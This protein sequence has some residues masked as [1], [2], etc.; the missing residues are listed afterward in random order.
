MYTID[1][2]G[3]AGWGDVPVGEGPGGTCTNATNEPGTSDQDALHHVT[4]PGYYGGHPNPTRGNDGNTFNTSIPQSPVSTDNPVECDYRKSGGTESTAL[5]VFASSTN[6]I[7]EYT[8][9]NFGGSLKGELIAAG[10]VKDEIYRIELNQAG[11]AVTA[12]QVL[13]SSVVSGPLDLVTKGDSGPGRPARSGSRPRRAARSSSSSR[14]TSA[15]AVPRAADPTIRRSTR[16]TTGTR[17]PTRSTTAR[18]PVRPATCRR[19]GT[20]TTYR[21]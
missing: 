13:F 8:A 10:Y 6:G 9:S 20:T 12:N 3:N 4:G 19:T 14:T 17:T 11:T 7:A 16:T 18:I 5:T 21:T 1:N 2:G 15:A